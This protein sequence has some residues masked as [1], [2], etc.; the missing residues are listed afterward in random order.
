MKLENKFEVPRSPDDT[1]A[2]LLDVPQIVGCVPGAELISEEPDGV[3]KGRV[4]IRLGPVALKFNGSATIAESDPVA[5]TALVRAKGSDQQGRGNAGAT[6]RMQVLPADGGSLVVLET[7]LQLSGLVAQYGRAS[8]V[9]A[10]VSNEIVASFARSLRARI[11]GPAP[12]PVEG[13]AESAAAPAEGAAPP[14]AEP[15][16]KPKALGIG[17]FLKAL[18]VALGLRRAG[19][20]EA[21]QRG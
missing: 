1:F 9:I 11:A 15:E 3:Y 10:A 14:A 2:T 13:G 4:S 7:E 5:R 16:E 6:T 12:A 18:L 8:G 17:F 20:D 21:R 19:A